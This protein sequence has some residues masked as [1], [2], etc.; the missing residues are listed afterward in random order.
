MTVPREPAPAGQRLL[1]SS[2]GA[3]SPDRGE[4]RGDP[5][6]VDSWLVAE[7]RVRGLDLHERR[8]RQSCTGLAPALPQEAVRRF[9][10]AVRRELPTGGHW[11]PRIEAYRA[12]SPQLTLWLRPAPERGDTVA[13]WIPSRSDPRTRPGVKGPDLAV[14][15]ALRADAR[16]AGADDAL[17]Y[18]EDGTA[19]EAAHSALVWW[20][21]DTLCVPAAGLPVL[22]SVTRVML[23][24]LALDRRCRLQAEHSTTD[25]LRR[26][27]VW[28]LN[29]LHGIRPVRGW[30]DSQGRAVEA[31]MSTRVGSWRRAL[32]ARAM[33]SAPGG[34]R[35]SGASSTPGAPGISGASGVSGPP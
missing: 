19:L 26:L 6:V 16:A 29:A 12:P 9:L 3:W 17:L 30:V 27:E 31:R 10:A 2:D 35:T 13:L 18:S 20:R 11:F 25:D 28:T 32:H 14:M 5:S 4:P 33:P 7:G 23:E 24:R 21:G 8:F 15:A 34:G 1:W 22:P